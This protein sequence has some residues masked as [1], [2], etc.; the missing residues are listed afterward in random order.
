MKK[1]L[2]SILFLG[3]FSVSVNAENIEIEMK[4]KGQEEV[5][6]ENKINNIFEVVKEQKI[7]QE[8]IKNYTVELENKMNESVVSYFN[9]IE[10]SLDVLNEHKESMTKELEDKIISLKESIKTTVDDFN[11]KES[12]IELI[13]S[14]ND[15][16]EK[17]IDIMNEY[18][19]KIEEKIKEHNT[20][21]VDEK[22]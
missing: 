5:T 16:T 18:K 2:L 21:N 9:E 3:V 10:T 4:E 22:K 13:K 12:N 19:I 7:S 14:L 8:D 20:Q 15:I 6:L 11:K 17:H 1:T